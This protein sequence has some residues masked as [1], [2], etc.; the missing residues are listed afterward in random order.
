MA[1]IAV[2]VFEFLHLLLYVHNCVSIAK[3]PLAIWKPQNDDWL[4]Y[5]ELYISILVPK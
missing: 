3:S 5:C 1:S 2:P 4:A